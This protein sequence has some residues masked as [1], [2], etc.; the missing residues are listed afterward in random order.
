VK[1]VVRTSARQGDRELAD[2]IRGLFA[3]ELLSPSK[4]VYLVSAW[5]TNVEVFDNRD[6]SFNGLDRD[7]APRRI[8][9]A[10]VLI[11]L[12]LKGAIVRV[13]TNDDVHNV[14]FLQELRQLSKS[15]GCAGRVT[16]CT[17]SDLHVKGLVTDSFHLSGSMNFT[18]NGINVNG[19]E[20]VLFTTPDDVQRA[21]ID[22]EQRYLNTGVPT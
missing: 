10:E 19:E 13:V 20:V 8:F 9:L 21:Q 14:A 5:I 7:L 3:L 17:V 1:R 2:L 22:Y 15:R 11:A 6:A 18:F 12:A 16:I 4:L